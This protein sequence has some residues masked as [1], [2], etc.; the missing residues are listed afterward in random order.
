MRYGSESISNR[1]WKNRSAP[2]RPRVLLRT[3]QS[4]RLCV[5]ARDSRRRPV[6]YHHPN[7][8]NVRPAQ[9]WHHGQQTRILSANC[10][11]AMANT[12]PDDMNERNFCVMQ[13]A[14]IVNVQYTK[15][16]RWAIQSSRKLGVL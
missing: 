12:S 13:E 4:P 2:F 16:E 3:P 8:T 6:S 7:I 14:D 5:A 10:K 15:E 1:S 9:R 11:V